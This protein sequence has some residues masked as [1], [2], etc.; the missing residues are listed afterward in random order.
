MKNKRI[1]TIEEEIKV[2]TVTKCDQC[3]SII[4]DGELYFHINKQNPNYEDTADICG[5]SSCLSRN[6]FDHVEDE[7]NGPGFEYN[8]QS[9]IAKTIIE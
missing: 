6:L 5:D 7:I 1:Q 9:M 8:I 3:G 4:P 2:I